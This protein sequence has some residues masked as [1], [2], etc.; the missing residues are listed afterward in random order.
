VRRPRDLVALV[1]S[2]RTPTAADFRRA[3]GSKLDC[4]HQ[5]NVEDLDALLAAVGLRIAA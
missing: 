5:G 3:N 4:L 1:G 2:A